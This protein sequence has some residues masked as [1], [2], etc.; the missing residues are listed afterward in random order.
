VLGVDSLA[1]IDGSKLYE[2]LEPVALLERFAAKKATR[3][4]RNNEF[5]A[6][7]G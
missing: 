3:V 7:R 1:D 5:L 2:V 6:L 4:G